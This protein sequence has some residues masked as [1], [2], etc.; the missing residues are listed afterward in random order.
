MIMALIALPFVL[1]PSLIALSSSL[2]ADVA[3]LTPSDE[4][5]IWQC[6]KELEPIGSRL[7]E[8]L[9]NLSK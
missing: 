6:S 2:L 1:L 3:F 5:I 9:G 8:G 4:P 7:I